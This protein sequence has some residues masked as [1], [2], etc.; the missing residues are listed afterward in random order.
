M[1]INQTSVDTGIC[2]NISIEIIISLPWNQFAQFPTPNSNERIRFKSIFIAS[3]AIQYCSCVHY[4]SSFV[5]C[6][7]DLDRD[8]FH[9]ISFNY[10]YQLLFIL[11]RRLDWIY[12]QPIYQDGFSLADRI[13]CGPIGIIMAK[14]LVNKIH[15]IICLMDFIASD[16]VITRRNDSYHRKAFAKLQCEPWQF[17]NSNFRTVMFDIFFGSDMTNTNTSTQKFC[18]CLNMASVCVGV[19]ARSF[20]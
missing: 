14:S 5:E 12:F 18:W 1:T 4:S 9:S 6:S 20:D 15:H 16:V 17:S 8:H 19:L 10:R 7:P 2:A 11:P 3:Q 13:I